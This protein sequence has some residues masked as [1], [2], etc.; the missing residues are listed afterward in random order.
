MYVQM[1]KILCTYPRRAK[2]RLLNREDVGLESFSFWTLSKVLVF[3][4]K[5]KAC[6]NFCFKY[7]TKDEVQSLNVSECDTPRSESCRIESVCLLLSLA[8]S[9]FEIHVKLYHV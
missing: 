3:I 6:F 7:A 8:P 2:S 5:I 4:I 1:F 9:C